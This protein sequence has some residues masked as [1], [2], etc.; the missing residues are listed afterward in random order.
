MF[1]Q[2]K[3]MFAGDVKVLGEPHVARGPAVPQACTRAPRIIWNFEWPLIPKTYTRQV[4]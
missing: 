1:Y 3:K 2:P 4:M